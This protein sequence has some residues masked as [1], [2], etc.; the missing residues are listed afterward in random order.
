MIFGSDNMVGASAAVLQAIVQANAGEQPSYG[1]DVLCEQAEQQ[2]S[3]AFQAPVKVF[4]V[5]TGTVANSLAL[6]ALV[7]PW[8]GV[9]C[10]RDAH[11][12]ADESSAPEFFSGGARLL[13]LDPVNGKLVPQSIS[14]ALSAAG[15]PP[16][17]VVPR[18][19]SITQTNELG[20]VYTPG[21]VHELASLAHRNGLKVHMDGA[22]FANALVSLGCHPADITWRAGVD[23]LCLGAS[24]N[25]AL[26]AEAIVFFD[27]SLAQDF[28]YRVKRAGQM[29][30]KARFFG[31]QFCAWLQDDHWLA[32]ARQANDVAGRLGEAL[33]ALPGT[34]VVWP[35]Q[36]N[37]VFAILPE[38]L[39][40]AL[41]TQGAVFYDWPEHSL[42]AHEALKHEEV[43]VRFVTSFAS[44]GE[45]VD[46][47][48]EAARRA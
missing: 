22:R 7:P 26:M 13:G 35:V 30:A 5:S 18:A 36:A 8:G 1:A 38:R 34:R 15:H 43:L 2:I 47:L 16:H 29:A 20:L 17:N 31:A 48:I 42:P 23:V 21:E 3:Q 46:D 9:L 10:Q 14:R 39:A 45:Q 41:R 25:G 19:L 27:L 24:K 40:Q 28:A 32:L 12:L 11:V 37:E 4:F 33:Q 6:S 44:A